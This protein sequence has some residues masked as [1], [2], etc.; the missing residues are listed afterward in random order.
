MQGGLPYN[1]RVCRRCSHRT[2]NQLKRFSWLLWDTWNYNIMFTHTYICVS[3]QR[4]RADAS[5]RSHNTRALMR[6][7]FAHLIKHEISHLKGLMKWTY[8]YIYV[9][10]CHSL[11]VFFAQRPQRPFSLYPHYHHHHRRHH[12]FRMRHMPR[13]S[14]AAYANV[15]I[16]VNVTNF[17][18]KVY[19]LYYDMELIMGST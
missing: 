8:I 11:G 17:A 19:A 6:N 5:S 18:H 7:S 1:I 15:I 14:E 4:Q 2:I 12:L 16:T 9:F 3:F 10:M 13:R